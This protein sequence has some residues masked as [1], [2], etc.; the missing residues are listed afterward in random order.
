MLT[1]SGH[2]LLC[3]VFGA[4]LLLRARK[5]L[6]ASQRAVVYEDKQ[7]IPRCGAAAR[8]VK[9]QH[10]S[11]AKILTGTAHILSAQ[12]APPTCTGPASML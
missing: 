12:A 8:V 9:T 1:R 3:Q 4:L 7:E 2:P 6:P 10:K 11:F 5:D